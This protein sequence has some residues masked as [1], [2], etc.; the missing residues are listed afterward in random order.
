MCA[1]TIIWFDHLSWK[2][3]SKTFLAD[4]ARRFKIKRVVIG[5]NHNFSGNEE[6]LR[7]RG[8]EVV[9]LDDPTAKNMLSNFIQSRNHGVA[10]EDFDW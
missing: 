7:S 8:I 10:I 2:V 5:E 9:I 4:Y 3:C 6:L 1:G